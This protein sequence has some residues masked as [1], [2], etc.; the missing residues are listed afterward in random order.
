MRSENWKAFWL[1]FLLT[2]VVMAPGLAAAITA[3]EWQQT[4]A[5]E[6][7]SG[8]P[9]RLPDE[10]HQLTVLAVTAGSTPGFVLARLD[11][12]ENRIF[13]A[14]IPAQS[15]PAAGQPTLAESYAAA[16]PARVARLLA[17][18]L[19]IPVDRYLAASPAV[20][21]EILAPAGTVRVGLGGAL[22]Q[23]QRQAAGLADG[24]ESWT[25]T[26]ANAFLTHLET[27]GPALPPEAIARG[28]AALWQGWARQK[29]DYLPRL[30]PSGL[31]AHSGVLL[32][33]LSATDLLTMEE[34]LEFLAD[35]KAQPEAGVLPGAWDAAQGC[36][37][38]TGDTLLWV[39]T[40]FSSAASAGASASAS[41]P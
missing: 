19:D 18:A 40:V 13:L 33:D 15:V 25:V 5:A 37:E 30:L 7:Q 21:Q 34:T 29:L 4:P 35:G 26:D 9:I 3:L 38:C 39:Q 28:R 24:M 8:V 1:A 6:S 10:R 27:L 12:V 32:T 16:G 41:E 22:T 2:L 20:W 31:A 36:Y 14:A 23:P 17:E 11:A